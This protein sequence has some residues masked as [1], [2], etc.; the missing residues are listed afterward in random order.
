MLLYNLYARIFVFDYTTAKA[1]NTIIA[2]KS[3]VR[4]GNIRLKI[5][6]EMF[7]NNHLPWQTW[8]HFSV[9]NIRRSRMK[10]VIWNEHSKEL[11]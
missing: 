8:I 10:F 11:R 1:T 3:I 7:Y 2:V 6:V 4:K 9:K 5:T